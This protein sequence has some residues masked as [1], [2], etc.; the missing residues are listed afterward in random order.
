MLISFRVSEVMKIVCGPS[1]T[2]LLRSARLGSML[3][4]EHPTTMEVFL[5][6]TEDLIMFLFWS[7][8]LKGEGQGLLGGQPL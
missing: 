1:S 3:Q 7:L 4:S 5:V 8:Q 2:Q 6:F